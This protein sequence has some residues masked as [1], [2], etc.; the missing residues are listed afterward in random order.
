MENDID[1]LESKV[2]FYVEPPVNNLQGISNELLRNV[3]LS[4]FVCSDKIKQE[5]IRV[6]KV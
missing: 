4:T 1:M 5:D 3:L 2:S 6:L